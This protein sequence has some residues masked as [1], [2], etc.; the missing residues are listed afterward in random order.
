MNKLWSGVVEWFVE[1]THS[2]N[3]STPRTRLYAASRGATTDTLNVLVNG[4]HLAGSR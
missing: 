3:R 4:L 2:T 1:R